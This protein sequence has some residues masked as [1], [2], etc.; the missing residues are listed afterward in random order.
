MRI[1]LPKEIKDQEGRVALTPEAVRQFVAAGH[2]VRVETGAGLGA[3]FPD[4]EYQAAGARLVS[5]AEAWA[6]ELVIKVK[7]PLE[8]EYGYLQQQLLFTFLHL[9]GVPRA[10]TETL[11][12]RGTSALA[13]ETLEDAQ[14]RLP[15]LAPMSAVAGN[16]AALVG[17][18]YLGRTHGGKGVQLGQV[19]GVRHGRALVI[20]DGV[21]AHHAARSAHG[22]GAEVVMAGLD[23][24]KGERYAAELGEGFRFIASSPEAI[25][26][27]L[28]DADLVVGAVLR[29]GAKA[30]Y[31]VTREQV[32]RL[33]P[34]SVVVDVSI[35]QGGCIETSRPT[36]HSH[37][38][39]VEHDVIHYCVTNMPGAYPRTATMALSEAVLPYALRLANA[40]LAALT[41]DP[42]FAKALNTHAG[43]LTLRTVAEDLG[44]LD[45]YRG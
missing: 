1:G 25:S 22:L 41:G 30:D 15:L 33:Q 9:S 16:M 11:L 5:V 38:L 7:E 36:S 31:V 18:Y 23:P 45:R 19:L 17:A 27:E 37:P 34:G 3:G 24:A 8:A 44:L 21:V 32:K 35:D 2:A 29:R 4:T 20:G 43:Y 13:Y 26:R 28:P 39:F 10:L 14:G 6:S 40:G 12:A 42:G